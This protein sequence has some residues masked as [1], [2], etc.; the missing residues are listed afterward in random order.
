MQHAPCEPEVVGG[1]ASQPMAIQSMPAVPGRMNSTQVNVAAVRWSATCH[2]QES[3]EEFPGMGQRH[4]FSAS[5]R[6]AGT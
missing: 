5:T 2:K 6:L 1:V 3:V 4:G